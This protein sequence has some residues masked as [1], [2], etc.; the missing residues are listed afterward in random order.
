[1][2][3]KKYMHQKNSKKKKKR[4]KEKMQ[5]VQVLGSLSLQLEGDLGWLIVYLG[6]S[7]GDTL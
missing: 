7:V 1:M 2:K 6:R 3:K 4:K 5:R